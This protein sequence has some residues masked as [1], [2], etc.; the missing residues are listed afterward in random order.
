MDGV[1]TI[2]GLLFAFKNVVME[3]FVLRLIHANAHLIGP[4]M[5]ANSLFVG[6]E[7]SSHFKRKVI[8]Y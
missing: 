3:V 7:I 8:N 2:V 5:P 1:G 6:R 4:G